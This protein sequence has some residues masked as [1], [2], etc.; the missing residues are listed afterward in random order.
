VVLVL[1]LVQDALYQVDHDENMDPQDQ[2][3]LHGKLA[4]LPF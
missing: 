2:G 3:G 1:I 4:D